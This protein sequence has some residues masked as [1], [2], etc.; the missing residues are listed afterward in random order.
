MADIFISYT[1]SDTAFVQRLS[2]ELE[3]FNVRGFLDVTDIASGAGLSRQLQE[4][5]ENADAILVVLSSAAR[6]TS[7]VMAEVGLAQA[8]NKKLIP[9]L[10]PGQAYNDSVPPQLLDRLV[11]DAGNYSIEE[12][13]ARIVAATTNTSVESALGEVESR[14][15]RRQKLL[16][17]TTVSFAL[18]TMM[19]IFMAVLANHQRNAAEEARRD[20]QRQQSAAEAARREAEASRERI[21]QLTGRSASLA[22][23]P[24]G[25]TLAI[26]GKDGSI[27]LLDPL[28][29]KMVET[30]TGHGGTITGLAY[31]P[32]GGL[33]ASADWSGE[34]KIWDIHT[35]RELRSLLGHDDAVI[36]LEFAPE[37]RSLY[38]RSLDGTI[39]EWDVGTGKLIRTL[40]PLE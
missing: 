3:R 13:A 14:Y 40:K 11:L 4:A 32:D 39:R 9:V 5:V 1:R 18:L 19:S 15:R 35:A 28:S 24:D 6:H 2:K 16:L 27:Q 8:L 37:G 36:G 12:V 10:A 22:L 31:S 33:L 29:G 17:A 26:G 21:E 23:A 25:K 34:V 38:S 7:W 30:L 20:A